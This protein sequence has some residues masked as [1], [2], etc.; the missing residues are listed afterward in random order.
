MNTQQADLV[1]SSFAL[2]QPI[3]PQAA[4]LFYAN[5]FE[6]DPALRGLFTGDMDQQGV[7]LMSMIGAAVG[8]LDRPA[9]LLPVLRVCS[10]LPFSSSAPGPLRVPFTTRLPATR[11]VVPAARVRLAPLSTV[12]LRAARVP[13]VRVG[14]KLVPAGT[15]TS[16]LA[17]G[18]TPASQLRQSAGSAELSLAVQMATWL[19]GAGVASVF[20]AAGAV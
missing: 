1:R 17:V 11:R 20:T 16:V 2:V 3:A 10:V 9:A 14:A 19:V 13:A 5:L 15:S 8:M 7:R 4:A 6:A 12:R 18:V